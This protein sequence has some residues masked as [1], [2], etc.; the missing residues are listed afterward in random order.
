MKINYLFLGVVVVMLLVVGG[1][2]ASAQQGV[3]PDV[4][5][6]TPPVDVTG[7]T[8]TKTPQTFTGLQNPIK[9]K[10]VQELL[11]LITDLIIFVGVIIAVLVF[12]FIGFKFVMAQGD[13]A[14]LKEARS[15]FYGAVIGTAILISAK[16]IVEVLQNTLVTAG[17][18]NQDL[19]KKQ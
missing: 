3:T 10:N 2:R 13:A 7:S 9:A 1:V 12:I 11:F 19:F 4:T 18:V 14:A 17:V 6:S 8:P 15:F 16:L 5:G